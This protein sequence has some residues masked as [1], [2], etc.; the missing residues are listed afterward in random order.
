MG[1]LITFCGPENTAKRTKRTNNKMVLFELVLKKMNSSLSL[2]SSYEFS[3]KNTRAT[4]EMR[5][6][7]GSSEVSNEFYTAMNTDLDRLNREF[8]YPQP[9]NV[10]GNYYPRFRCTG[11][12][13]W[14]LPRLLFGAPLLLLQRAQQVRVQQI[15]HSKKDWRLVRE[16]NITIKIT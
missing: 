16:G 7:R 5:N 8:Y 11:D 15:L 10:T 9:I 13:D 12:S 14:Q 4:S 2:S 1:I 6:L 3:S